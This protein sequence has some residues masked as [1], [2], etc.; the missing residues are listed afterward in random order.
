MAR[1][2]AR[3]FVRPLVAFGLVICGVSSGTAKTPPVPAAIRYSLPK[4][5]MVVDV[6]VERSKE[7]PGKYC[8]FLDLFFPELDAAA[9]CQAKEH[10]NPGDPQIAGRMKTAITGYSIALKGVPDPSRTYTVNFDA[11]WHVERTDS[12]TLTEGGTLTGAEMQR[13]DRT[14]EIIF[15]VLSNA[16]KIAG[17]LIF[18]AS[19]SVAL[20][21]KSDIPWERLERLAENF[22][23]L[24]SDRQKEYVK[25]WADAKRRP[26]LILATRSYEGLVDDAKKL[27][28]I[29]AG[30]GAQG[31]QTLI[32]ELRKDI[33]ETLTEDFLG[34]KAKDTWTPTYEIT[35]DAPKPNEQSFAVVL[36]KL[37]G[38]GVAEQTLVP[39]KNTLTALKCGKGQ[40]ATAADVTLTG[41]TASAKLPA[42]LQRPDSAA[43][44]GILF[45][46]L[47][48]P[49]VL[50]MAGVCGAGVTLGPE[51]VKDGENERPKPVEDPTAPCTFATQNA[52]LAQWG[53]RM[54]I[55][56][57]GKDY[58]YT[59]SLYEATGAVKSIK[60]TS[61]ATLD[62]STIDSAFGIATTLLD[63]KDTADAAAKKKAD[64]AATKADELNVLTRQRQI[65]DE[66]SKIKKLCDEL[67]LTTCES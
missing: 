15:G 14:A 27:D 33:A 67:G 42:R 21:P 58:A 64:E 55:P 54:S 57:A 23:M 49:V 45:H 24:D 12:L 62:K 39:V 47:P 1:T 6:Q 61:K 17:R 25:A 5:T 20:V 19:T 51:K 37:A 60:L 41:A 66:K 18:G 26:R 34:S 46:L 32:T 9:A 35:R 3:S 56:K 48:E 38:C 53:E 4:T 36:F 52:L 13:A 29:L 7:A 22:R 44:D 43:A 10:A 40:Y 31:A 63:A 65:L 11:S 2:I 8:D 28:S 30:T 50:D 59:L 16:A